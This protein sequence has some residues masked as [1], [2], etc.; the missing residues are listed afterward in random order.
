MNAIR[1]KKMFLFNPLRLT[2]DGWTV[3]AEC[4]AP[5]VIRQVAERRGGA[6]PERRE[7]AFLDGANKAADQ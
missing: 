2:E 1:H 4:P 6:S 3:N 7:S 5:F